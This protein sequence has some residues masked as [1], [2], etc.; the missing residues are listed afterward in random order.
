MIFLKRPCP[1]LHTL[2]QKLT[3]LYTLSHKGLKCQESRGSMMSL[4]SRQRKPTQ[5]NY[6]MDFLV[7]EKASTISTTRLMIFLRKLSM[8]IS[9]PH[10]KQSKS[11]NKPKLQL[12]KSKM[13]YLM[14][15]SKVYLNPSEVPVNL[16]AVSGTLLSKFRKPKTSSLLTFLL[17]EKASR[18]TIDTSS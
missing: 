1:Y 5:L 4:K 11:S 9:L 13:I 10:N 7:W 12:N 2:Y 16:P 18:M 14:T 15:L 3:S 17:T 6:P 8:L